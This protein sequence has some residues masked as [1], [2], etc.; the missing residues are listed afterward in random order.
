MI[1]AELHSAH[2]YAAVHPA[3]PRALE[4]LKHCFTHGAACGRHE[5]DGDDL[6]A[7]VME[8]TPAEKEAPRFETHNRYIDIQCMLRGSECQWYLPRKDLQDAGAYNPEKDVTFYSFSGV[9]SRLVLNPGDLAVYFPEDGH[10]PGMMADTKD[11]CVRI[12]VKI[13]C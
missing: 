2:L 3:F 8:Y 5:I 4:F 7:L 10:L 11:Y 13:K 6:Y 12:V 1:L 9:G